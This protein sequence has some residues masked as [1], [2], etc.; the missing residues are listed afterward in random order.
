MILADTSLL[1]VVGR[2]DRVDILATL[3]GAI[4]IP[5]I[6]YREAVEQSTSHLQ[7]EALERG[8]REG[9]MIVREPTAEPPFS[10]RLDA[11]ERGVLALAREMHPQAI[12]LDDRKA[13]NEAQEMGFWLFYTSD[14]LKAVETRGLIS[15]YRARPPNSPA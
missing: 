10:R 13:R 9:V 7:R 12:I 4:A 2:L 6:V 15:S 8:V 1:I 14:V 3:F 11:G 5:G